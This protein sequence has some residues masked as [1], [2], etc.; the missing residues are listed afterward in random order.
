MTWCLVF[1]LV[2]LIENQQYYR[3]RVPNV[4]LFILFT[5]RFKVK[6]KFI[7]YRNYIFTDILNI[8]SRAIFV[9]TV[10]WF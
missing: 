4:Y 6:I 9:A 10:L 7:V 5:K 1:I 2:S 8:F 3:A